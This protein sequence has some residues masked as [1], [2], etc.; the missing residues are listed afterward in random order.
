MKNGVLLIKPHH[1]LDFLYDLAINNRHNEPNPNENAN[2]KL[3]R[4]FMNGEFKTIIFTPFVDDICKPC[5]CLIDG[6]TCNQSFDDETTK[7]YGVRSK[8]DFNHQLDIK[9]NAALPSV[10]VFDKEQN[11]LNVLKIL[12]ESINDGVINL[13]PWDL[14]NRIQNTYLGIDKAINI[15]QNC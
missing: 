1:F 10:F 4:A 6:T 13:Y 7:K 11:I 3:C 8:N 5:K 9:L 12:K 15:Y 2:G 14:P